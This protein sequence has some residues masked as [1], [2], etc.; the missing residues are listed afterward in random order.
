MNLSIFLLVIAV[1]LTIF[2]IS[3]FLKYPYDIEGIDRKHAIDQFKSDIGL[4]FYFIGLSTSIAVI[5]A[6][7]GISIPQVITISLILYALISAIV[8]SLIN[9]PKIEG[10][11]NLGF[12]IGFI[13][14]LIPVLVAAYACLFIL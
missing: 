12:L 6:V 10:K 3:A 7:Y 11:P 2:S 8:A 13:A 5:I 9:R 14:G 4:D 1:P